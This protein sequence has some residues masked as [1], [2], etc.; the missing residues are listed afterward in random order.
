MFESLAR[1]TYAKRRNA[2]LWFQGY[3]WQTR[4]KGLRWDQNPTFFSE[5]IHLFF[6]IYVL[7]KNKTKSPKVLGHYRRVDSIANDPYVPK[8]LKRFSEAQVARYLLPQSV[9]QPTIKS[10]PEW[11]CQRYEKRL[12]FL[13]N[14]ANTTLVL[15]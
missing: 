11:K 3:T 10:A 5:N 9:K 13:V 4:I 1:Q 2:F 14:V 8:R 7:Q 12:T 6:D 15:K